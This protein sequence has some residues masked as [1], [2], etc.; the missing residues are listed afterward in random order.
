MTT[1]IS[2]STVTEDFSEECTLVLNAY[3]VAGSKDKGCKALLTNEFSKKQIVEAFS[4][5]IEKII[6]ITQQNENDDK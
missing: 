6:S 3:T 5:L 2:L 1:Q 4:Q